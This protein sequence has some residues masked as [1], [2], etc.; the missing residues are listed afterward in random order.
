MIKRVEGKKTPKGEDGILK[1]EYSEEFWN[2][3]GGGV[4]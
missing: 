1:E 3:L 4:V 2:G